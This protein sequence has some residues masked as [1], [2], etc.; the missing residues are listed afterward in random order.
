M[1]CQQIIYPKRKKKIVGGLCP[2]PAAW[3]LRIKGMA[4]F[5][6]YICDPHFQAYVKATKGSKREWS[7]TPLKGVPDEKT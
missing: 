4:T 5:E 7:A 1:Q 3:K 6:L 2:T